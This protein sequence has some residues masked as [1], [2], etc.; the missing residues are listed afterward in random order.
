MRHCDILFTTMILAVLTAVSSCK[1]DDTDFGDV[2]P[3]PYFMPVKIAFDENPIEEMAEVIDGSDNDYVENVKFKHVVSV[4]YTADGAEVTG[5]S[6]VVDVE[7]CGGHVTVRSASKSVEYRLSGSC[8]DGSFKVYSDNKFKL[9]LDNL[10]LHN[11]EGAAVNNQCGKSM[12]LVLTE[13]SNNILS[14]GSQVV[15][16]SDED[17]KGALF[18]E[19]QILISGKGRLYVESDFKNGIATDDYLVVRPGNVIAVKSTAGNAVK[20]NDG[21]YVR[22]SVLNLH[23]DFP[24]GKGI[25]CESD[26]VF[27]GGRTTIITE[28]DCFIEANDTTSSAAVKSDSTVCVTGGELNLLAR[29]SGGKGVNA[30][31]GICIMGGKVTAVTLGDAHTASPNALKSD[32][33]IAL[34]GGS[35]YAYSR[36]AQAVRAGAVASF[37]YAEGYQ[38]LEKKGGWFFSIGY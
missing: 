29:G 13:A 8:D 37:S 1:S 36:Y 21:V 35:L 2:I 30:N 19:G 28:G 6:G 9:V 25:N 33:D 16:P 10:K 34:S 31:G 3:D 20:A 24:G 14:T 4:N 38:S 27:S 26:I 32:G 12:Y 7:T 17:M 22:G 5:A 18:S 11:P 23:T 15:I